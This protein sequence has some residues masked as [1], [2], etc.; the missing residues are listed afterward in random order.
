MWGTTGCD[1]VVF[2]W[3]IVREI[4]GKFGRD[5]DGNGVD[6]DDGSVSNRVISEVA[7]MRSGSVCGSRMVSV[8]LYKRDGIG[9]D[10]SDPSEIKRVFQI[11]S[12]RSQRRLECWGS[13][14]RDVGYTVLCAMPHVQLRLRRWYGW[15]GMGWSCKRRGPILKSSLVVGSK[16]M[17]LG[18]DKDQ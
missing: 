18:C 17:Y 4:V 15:N 7:C 12:P 8:V 1:I 16:M 2:G 11:P 10:V 9:S 5:G 6:G 3:V 13:V 14:L